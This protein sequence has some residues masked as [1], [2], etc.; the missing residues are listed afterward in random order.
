MLKINLFNGEKITEFRDKK[1]GPVV[2][3]I[4]YDIFYDR[5]I[6]ATS[7]NGFIIAEKV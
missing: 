7:G 5:V 6:A 1:D 4:E 3:Y 2:K